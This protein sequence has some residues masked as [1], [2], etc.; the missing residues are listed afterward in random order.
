M[1]ASVEISEYEYYN[2]FTYCTILIYSYIHIHTYL[3]I[4]TLLLQAANGIYGLQPGYDAVLGRINTESRDSSGWEEIPFEQSIEIQK[5]RPGSGQ[6][7]VIRKMDGPI[8]CIQ[9]QDVKLNPDEIILQRDSVWNHSSV[10]NNSVT[11][12]TESSVVKELLVRV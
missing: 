5:L 2:F 10:F 7:E 8:K 3:R 6:L 11:E 12:K 1:R 4:I 9:I